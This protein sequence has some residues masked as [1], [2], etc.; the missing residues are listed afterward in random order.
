VDEVVVVLEVD[1]VVP[2]VVAVVDV[3]VLRVLVVQV[4][5]LMVDV[6]DVAEVVE[7]VDEVAVSQHCVWSG[8]SQ[9]CATGS[10]GPVFKLRPLGH[11]SLSQE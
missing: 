1:V 4:V 7:A 5:V 6:D 9:A 10:M 11:A 2:V 8:A 3:V